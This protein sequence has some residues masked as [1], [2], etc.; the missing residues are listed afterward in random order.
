MAKGVED[1]AM[2]VY[3]RLISMNEVGGVSRK[4]GRA[5][6]FHSF[7]SG[8]AP[9]AAHDERDVDARHQTERGCSRAHKCAFRDPG[10]MD[11]E[12]NAMEPMACRQTRRGDSQRRVLPL[13]DTHRR[14]AA[15]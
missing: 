13:S 12:R 7:L 1:S 6:Q 8:G 9:M 3:N 14:V 15:A 5:M 2:Y 10:R 11:P 4:H